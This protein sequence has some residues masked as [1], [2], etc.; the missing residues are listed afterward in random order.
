MHQ[1]FLTQVKGG[2]VVALKG[3]RSTG[4]AVLK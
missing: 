4:V 2:K 3:G 1:V